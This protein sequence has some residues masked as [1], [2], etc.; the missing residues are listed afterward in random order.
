MHISPIKFKGTWGLTWG[1]DKNYSRGDRI[2]DFI[3]D[4]N[5]CLLNYGSYTYL[6][7]VP[8]TFTAIDLSLCSPD[9]LMEIDFMV[10]SD[11]YGSDH[12]P[13]VL[14]IGISLPDSLDYFEQRTT[15]EILS[16]FRFFT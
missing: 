5:V 10:E 15:E 7:P 6:H 14:K 13:I 8:G 3:T 12:F 11:S 16:G 2:A 1:C 4:N 9:I